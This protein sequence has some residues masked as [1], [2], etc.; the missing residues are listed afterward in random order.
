MLYVTGLSLLVDS[1]PVSR[2]S[3]SLTGDYQ[4]RIEVGRQCLLG[5]IRIQRYDAVPWFLGR[6]SSINI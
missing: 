4:L 6:L 3:G 2:T 1:Q 5:G